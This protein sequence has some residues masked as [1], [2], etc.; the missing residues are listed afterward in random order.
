MNEGL[1]GT[2][3]QAAT[4]RSTRV[5]LRAKPLKPGMKRK[6][7]ANPT[8]RFVHTLIAKG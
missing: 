1:F 8:K 4:A 2:T 6:R 7:N 3:A 5:T